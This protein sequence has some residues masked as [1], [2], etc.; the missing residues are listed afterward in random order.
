MKNSNCN[1][2]KEEACTERNL[3]LVDKASFNTCFC[4]ITSLAAAILWLPEKYWQ[5]TL[6][7]Y[8]QKHKANS[9]MILTQVQSWKLHCNSTSF[10]LIVALNMKFGI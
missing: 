4:N 8:S 5:T 6:D 1:T 2:A 10:Q 9:S 3:A 7:Q